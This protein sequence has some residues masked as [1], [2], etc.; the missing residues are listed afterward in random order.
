MLF[1]TCAKHEGCS[2]SGCSMSLAKATCLSQN[3]LHNERHAMG[4]LQVNAEGLHTP[5]GAKGKVTCT[6]ASTGHVALLG[7]QPP[8]R[9]LGLV[10]TIW[11]R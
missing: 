9:V 2:I 3:D 8:G 1:Y 10:T 7:F 5:V 6:A 4:C 11:S